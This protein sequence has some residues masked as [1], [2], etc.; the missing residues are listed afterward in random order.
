MW[1]IQKPVKSKFCIFKNFMN[2]KLQKKEQ[3]SAILAI[4]GVGGIRFKDV[5]HVT[6]AGGE[7]LHKFPF[8]YIIK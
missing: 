8:E 4:G 6:K 5:C 3:A 7:I 2:C 1:L